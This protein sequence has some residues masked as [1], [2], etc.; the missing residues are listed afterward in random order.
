M[1][2]VMHLTKWYRATP[3]VQ[4]VSFHISRGQILGYLGPNGSG[5]STTVKM[6]TGLVPPS[7]GEIHLDGTRVWL[8]DPSFLRK[9]GYVPEEP[10]LYSYLTQPEN[11]RLVGRLHSIPHSLLEFKIDGLLKAFS[12]SDARYGLISDYSKG[13]RQKILLSAALLHN[14]EILILDEPF[15]RLDVGAYLLLRSLL[16]TFAKLGKMILYSSHVLEVVEKICTEVVI[17]H[18]GKMV[19]YDSVA[20]LRELQASPSLESVFAQLTI[21]ED[22][23]GQAERIVEVMTA[24]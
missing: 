17:L 6:L 4:D 13:M 23:S 1:L 18:K 16:V 2:E 10:H 24:R 15:S 9:V 19:A 20:H 22:A 7:E 12:L 5:K 11:L 14:P 3:A 21:T 8:G